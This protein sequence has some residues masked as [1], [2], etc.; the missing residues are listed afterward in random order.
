ME[1]NKY[2]DN[3]EQELYNKGEDQNNMGSNVSR[4]S[5]KGLSGRRTQSSGKVILICYVI[6]YCC[7]F[8]F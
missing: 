6:K 3:I 5:G 1:N 2:H 7:F 4:H 8:F